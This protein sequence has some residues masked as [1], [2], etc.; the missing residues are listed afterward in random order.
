M[1]S[2]QVP[3]KFFLI[4]QDPH[5]LRNCHGWV[6]VIQLDGHLDVQSNRRKYRMRRSALPF[7]PLA[8]EKVV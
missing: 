3:A 5:Q 1:C 8:R 4:N 2:H 7:P 6:G